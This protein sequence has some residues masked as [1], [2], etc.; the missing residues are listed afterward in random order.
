MRNV[1]FWAL[2][3]LLLGLAWLAFRLFTRRDYK[4]Q[5]RLGAASTLLALL[6]FA[7]HANLAYLYLP[8]R[9]PALPSLPDNALQRLLGLGLL[10]G[11]TAGVVVAMAQLGPSA[12]FGQ[13][14]RALQQAG[15]YR[16][17]RN[18]QILCYVVALSG[19][20]LLWPSWYAL[21]W[22]LLYLPIAHMMVVTEE[23]HLRRRYGEAFDAYCG[24]V[25]R[26]LGR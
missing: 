6:V 22:L 4:R 25:P 15:L 24:R 2:F 13:R 16:L 21:G 3:A 1:L 20:A 19:F 11:G 23:E 7:L 26:Y 12:V 10:A 8:A 14:S 17:T 5:G 18:P 9:W